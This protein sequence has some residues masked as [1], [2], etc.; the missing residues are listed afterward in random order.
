MSSYRMNQFAPAALQG[1]ATPPPDQAGYETKPYE[2]IYA[3]PNGLLTANQLINPDQVSIQTDADFYMAAWYIS[4]YTDQFQIQLIDATG[5]QLQ[6]GMINSGAIARSASKPTVFSPA[7]PFPAGSRIQVV[8]QD[9]S[10][11]DNPLQI[12]FKG[13]KRFRLPL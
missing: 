11:A 10:G 2:Y 8:I 6:A 9:L 5:Y 4:L 7:H 12:V 1:V 13:W 3:P